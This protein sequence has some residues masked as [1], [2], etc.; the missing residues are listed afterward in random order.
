MNDNQQDELKRIY[1]RLVSLNKN[2]PNDPRIPEFYVDEYHQLLDQLQKLGVDGVDVDEFRLPEE[3][4]R[5]RVV[6]GNG[7][8]GAKGG[9]G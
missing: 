9:S 5:Q 6:G 1:A 8:K 2:L 7:R 4:I 3:N